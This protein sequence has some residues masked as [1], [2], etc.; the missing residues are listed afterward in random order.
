MCFNHSEYKFWIHSVNL[1]LSCLQN[2]R[3]SALK[4]FISKSTISDFRKKE[5]VKPLKV[6]FVLEAAHSDRLSAL[7]R[8]LKSVSNRD[9][10]RFLCSSL[11]VSLWSQP[12]DCFG[13]S[14]SGWG[15]GISRTVFVSRTQT[16]ADHNKA[17]DEHSVFVKATLKSKFKW[18][19]GGGWR[20]LPLC[21]CVWRWRV[22]MTGAWLMV[23]VG[24]IAIRQRSAQTSFSSYHV[25]SPS[26]VHPASHRTLSVWDLLN[27]QTLLCLS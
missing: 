20:V 16:R 27:T 11:P 24:L 18:I 14:G 19:L 5:N 17:D 3:I 1:L 15:G 2:C 7:A 9:D 10:V 12:L 21:K 22:V 6:H 23:L 13:P 4:V 8:P 25:D 26:P